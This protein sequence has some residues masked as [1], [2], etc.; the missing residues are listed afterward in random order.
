MMQAPGRRGRWGRQSIP[1][2]DHQARADHH[3]D[4]HQGLITGMS[5]Q[6]HPPGPRPSDWQ[7]RDGPRVHAVDL[8]R[9]SRGFK[10][11]SILQILRVSPTATASAGHAR[12][13][14]RGG[15]GRRRQ[16]LAK[17]DILHGESLASYQ[18]PRPLKLFH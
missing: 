14:G 6:W 4:D 7:H 18:R 15:A 16:R 17:I 3:D 13:G 1:G 5:L 12:S 11:S 2:S 10:S 9:D 8:N